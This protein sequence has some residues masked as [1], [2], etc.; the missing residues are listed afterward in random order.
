M[1]YYVYVRYIEDNK[2]A[3]MPTSLVKDFAP[4]SPT[5]IPPGPV[6]AYWRSPQGTG[7]GFYS[8]KIV[9]LAGEYYLC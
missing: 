6:M 5:D 2:V 1:G 3:V 9:F 4:E 8:A 7:E